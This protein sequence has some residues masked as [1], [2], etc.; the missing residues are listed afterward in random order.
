MDQQLYSQA[1]WFISDLDRRYRINKE[2]G[3][4]YALRN[5]EFKKPLLKIG[6]TST[7]PHLR[8]RE[9]GYETGV[10]G[11]F[12]LIY[13]VHAVDCMYA[14]NFVHQQLAKYRTTGEFFE[15]SISRA[16][17][18]LDE[19]A[20]HYP[21]NMD[22]ARPKKRRS[23]AGARA[24]RTTRLGGDKW[25][26]QVFHHVVSPCPHCGQKNKIHDLAI[27]FRPK[28]G[29]CRRNLLGSSG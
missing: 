24:A 17:E 20:A 11:R 9:L 8:A 19:A 10:P 22:M 4:V 25:L 23:A 29:K 15:V 28:C 6:R 12:D 5:S 16:V 27:S 26:P 18:A 13:F 1:V 2:V 7:T 21:I 14:E 3:W